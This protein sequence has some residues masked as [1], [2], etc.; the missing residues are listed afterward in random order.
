MGKHLHG[1]SL[2]EIILV[3]SF[4]IIFIVIINPGTYIDRF[5]RMLLKMNVLNESDLMVNKLNGLSFASC[6]PQSLTSQSFGYL[7][8]GVSFSI[9]FDQDQLR[10]SNLTTNVSAILYQHVDATKNNQF[11]YVDHL[12]SE[13]FDASDVMMIYYQLHASLLPVSL[14]GGFLCN[15]K[16]LVLGGF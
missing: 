11:S 10:V 12:F 2:L 4:I 3:T 7:V 5:S 16:S 8:D 9:Q 15:D 14:Q 13:T 1:Y 6:V